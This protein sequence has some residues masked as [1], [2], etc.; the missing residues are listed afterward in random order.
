VQVEIQDRT[1]KTIGAGSGFLAGERNLIATNYH[2]IEKAHTAHVVFPDGTLTPV[3]GVAALDQEAD[4]AILRITG[5]IS[6]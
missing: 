1:G 3:D 5:R 6:A 2:V 4:L